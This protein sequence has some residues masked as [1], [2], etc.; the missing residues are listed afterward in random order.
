[1]IKINSVFFSRVVW[2][3]LKIC[4]SDTQETGKE[5]NEDENE[6]VCYEIHIFGASSQL[7]NAKAGTDTNTDTDTDTIAD[8]TKRCIGWW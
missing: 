5:R 6:Q 2:M 3:M 8:A 7:P 4:G 1:M